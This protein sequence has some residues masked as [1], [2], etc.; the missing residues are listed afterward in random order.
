MKKKCSIK[1]WLIGTFAIFTLG[2]VIRAFTKKV[3]NNVSD[4]VGKG[5]TIL[6]LSLMV[7]TTSLSAKP[8]TGLSGI[9]VESFT[10]DTEHGRATVTIK[11]NTHKPLVDVTLLL[12]YKT[13]NGAVVEK[14]TIT[15]FTYCESGGKVDLVLPLLF[16]GKE[17]INKLS[18]IDCSVMSFNDDYDE[19]LTT[20][21]MNTPSLFGLEK[22]P[23]D[24]NI[25]WKM[26]KEYVWEI[27][28][29]YLFIMGICTVIFI[30][31]TYILMYYVYVLA[32][33][34]NRSALA[35]L[36]LA[37]F[38]TP[39]VVIALLLTLG[40]PRYDEVHNAFI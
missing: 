7:T 5:L 17:T 39:P 16:Y 36:F 34:N 19:S 10:T 25:I 15:R 37:C 18:N 27:F 26:T 8:A 9:S 33:K 28:K 30:V 35:W 11:N 31:I 14:D 40:R 1:K 21:M 13:G 20:D 38:T 12:E 6:C 4:N 3:L 24:E 32:R 2:M 23:T 22:N 29:S